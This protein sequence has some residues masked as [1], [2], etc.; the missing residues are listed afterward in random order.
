[1]TVQVVNAQGANIVVQEVGFFTVLDNGTLALCY[2]Y[3][4]EPTPLRIKLAFAP[5]TWVTCQ[6]M[7]APSPG[8]A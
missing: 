7:I 5:N 3:A 6:E 8:P 2:G 1:M 4:E